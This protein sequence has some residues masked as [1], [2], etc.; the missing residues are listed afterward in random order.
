MAAKAIPMY[1]VT[2]SGKVTAYDGGRAANEIVDFV[3]KNKETARPTTVP[4]ETLQ[5][6]PPL[7]SP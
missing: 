4:P 3:K 1:L 5:T 6:Q 7:P 2:A